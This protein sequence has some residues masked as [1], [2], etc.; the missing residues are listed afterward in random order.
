M[1]LVL[2]IGNFHLSSILRRVIKRGWISQLS[3][4]TIFRSNSVLASASL[5]RPVVLHILSHSLDKARLH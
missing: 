2:E 4:Q 3:H 5:D 1:H